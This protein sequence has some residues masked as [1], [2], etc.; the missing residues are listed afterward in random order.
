MAGVD[1]DATATVA[2]SDSVDPDDDSGLGNGA[3]TSL[4]SLADGPITATISADDTAGNSA[5][6]TGDSSTKAPTAA[7]PT[8]LDL[9]AVD[10]TGTSSIDNVTKNTSALTITGS[11]ENGTTVT[12]YDDVNDNGVQ[13]GGEATLETALVSGGGFT[14]D[15]SLTAGTHHVGAFETDLAGNVSSGAARLDITVDTT[16]P[17]ISSIDRQT[18]S[19]SPTNADSLT[20]RVTLSEAA[21]N[22]DAG[23]FTVGGT[24]ATVTGV[25]QINSST[26]D[27]TIS[28]GNLAGLNGTVTLG[29]AGGQNIIDTAGN[30]LTNTTPTGTN[31]NFYTLDNTGPTATITAGSTTNN[32]ATGTAVFNITFSDSVTGVS[33]DDFSEFG[34][35]NHI[36]TRVVAGSGTSYTYTVTYTEGNSTNGDTNDSLGLNLNSGTNV[37]DTAGNVA[38][39]TSYTQEQFKGGTHLNPAG[40]AGESINLALTDPSSDHIG[41]ITI[42]ISGVPTG[43]TLSEG[44]DNGDG[45]WTVGTNDVSSLAITSPDTFAGA[46]VLSVT[47]TWTNA[48]GTTGTAFVSDNVE[49]YAPGSPIFAW[50]GDDTLTASSGSDLIVFAQP[51]GNDVV[52]NFD[53]TADK[54]DLIGFDGISGFND[55]QAHLSSNANGDAVIT[56]ADGQTITLVGVNAASLTADDFVFDL[57]PVT[58]N[59][60]TMTIGDGAMLPLSGIINNT[61]TIELSSAGNQTDLELIQHGITL[62][63]GGQVILSDSSGNVIAG[64]DAS[65]T[66]TNVDNTISGSGQL[67][68][69]SMTLVNEGTIDATGTDALVID[70]G[71]NAITNS[72]TLEASGSGGLVVHG[73]ILNS[74]L[75]WAD[76]G[77]IIV[78]GSVTGDGSVEISGL[79]TLDFGG[80][81]S[82]NVLFD[83]TATGTLELDQSALF[84]GAI[85][86]FNSDDVLDLGDIQF[87]GATTV[88]Y[89]ANQDNSGGVL[90]VSDG[91]HTANISLSGQYSADGFHAS[92][93][94]GTGTLVSYVL[95]GTT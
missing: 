50:S 63:G 6:S 38:A 60:G 10:D 47:E 17:T 40:V 77:N 80:L 81:L 30:S 21:A 84:T 88:S 69:G 8:G 29:F 70:T 66:L 19:S 27:V 33:V 22:V 75:L 61:G 51:I 92:G 34:T 52:H 32:G 87:S 12:L 25:S 83:A 13:D 73:D 79:A 3:T 71:G 89:A 74:G 85:S 39:A 59:S 72:G 1:A 56:L 23:D 20:F 41:G 35:A 7:A 94:L 26:Y 49:A 44:T 58:E 54:I 48:D 55:V 82:E 76:G 15:I 11:A 90:T 95:T 57:M 93:D 9:A 18:P 65:V 16:A 24:T 5:S 91:T 67:G 28:G 42:T 53:V 86:G 4:S 62:Q 46:I 68:G 37:I 64:T 14:A 43:W 2:Y 45:T 78:D 36:L 31:N